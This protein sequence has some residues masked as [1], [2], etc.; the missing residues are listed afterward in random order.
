MP[1]WSDIE[2]AVPELAGTAAEEH[3]AERHRAL[4]PQADAGAHLFR[5]DITEV[6]TVQVSAEVLT[7]WTPTHGIRILQRACGVR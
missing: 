7:G 5:L 3:N 4:G 6:V 1:G 2:V